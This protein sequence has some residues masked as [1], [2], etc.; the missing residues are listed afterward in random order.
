LYATSGSFLSICFYPASQ[1]NGKS[2]FL[3][4]CA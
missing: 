4:I 1:Y 3:F 2:G